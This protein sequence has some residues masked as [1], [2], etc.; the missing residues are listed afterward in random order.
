MSSS[1]SHHSSLSATCA[2]ATEK[3]GSGFFAHTLDA[4]LL[5]LIMGS[6]LYMGNA[7]LVRGGHKDTKHKRISCCT[8]NDRRGMPM[9]H[10]TPQGNNIN[11][12]EI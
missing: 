11:G 7:C 2:D 4:P 1:E 6:T 3:G 8:R 12:E 5:A 9:A 10:H